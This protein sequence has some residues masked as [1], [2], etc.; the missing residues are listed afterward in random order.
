MIRPE[1]LRLGVVEQGA[2][3][4]VLA[5]VEAARLLG[6]TSLVHLS[7]PD[8]RGGTLHLHSRMPGQYLPADG[9]HVAIA[10]DPAQ[11]FAFP[12]TGP[13]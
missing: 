1:A 4:S 10:L 5:R 6:R 2:T 13:I 7:V 3:M 8:G 11:A 9:T 12:V